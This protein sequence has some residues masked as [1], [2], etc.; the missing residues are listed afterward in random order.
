[1]DDQKFD[2]FITQMLLNLTLRTLRSQFELNKI[3]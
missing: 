3:F 1:M 2:Y